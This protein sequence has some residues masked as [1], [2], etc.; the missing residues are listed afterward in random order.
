MSFVEILKAQRPIARA[1]TAMSAMAAVKFEAWTPLSFR[2]KGAGIYRYQLHVTTKISVIIF[3]KSFT[4]SR[5]WSYLLN[6]NW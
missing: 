1:P 3:L 2:Q 5:E 4:K 6:G